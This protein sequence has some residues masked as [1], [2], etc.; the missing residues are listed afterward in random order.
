MIYAPRERMEF[1]DD[2]HKPAADEATPRI[3]AIDIESLK[4]PIGYTKAS[5]L[6][7]CDQNMPHH[8]VKVPSVGRHTQC[9]C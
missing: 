8:S 5:H 3:I 7:R 6:F 1:I 2:V 9:C 4:H